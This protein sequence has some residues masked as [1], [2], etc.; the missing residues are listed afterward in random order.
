M[1]SIICVNLDQSK[2]L[3]SGNGLTLYQRDRTKYKA[4]A[5]ENFNMSKMTE[6]V[7]E[8]NENIFGKGENTSQQPFH[9]LSKRSFCR[10]VQSWNCVVKV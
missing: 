6:F 3:S 8:R 9:K 5:D 10:V 2:I 1:P 7:L 4:F